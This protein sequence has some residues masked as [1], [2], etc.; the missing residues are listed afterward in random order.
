M[1]DNMFRS[2]KRRKAKRK[3]PMQYGGGPRVSLTAEQRSAFLE[4][5]E[6]LT[7][8]LHGDKDER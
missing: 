8:R 4:V 6:Q 5:H 3:I 7:D 1:T 2:R